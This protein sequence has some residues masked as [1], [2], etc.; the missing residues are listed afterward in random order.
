M[1]SKFDDGILVKGTA[2][3]N[4]AFAAFLRLFEFK[5]ELSQL[6]YTD[7]VRQ[8]NVALI[9]CPDSKIIFSLKASVRCLSRV[10]GFLCPKNGLKSLTS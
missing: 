5:F 2:E 10:A 8:T 6:F 9:I 3:M 1:R 4:R 7:L